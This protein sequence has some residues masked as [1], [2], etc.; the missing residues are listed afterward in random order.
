ML[1]SINIPLYFNKYMQGN[2]PDVGSRDSPCGEGNEHS[3][4]ILRTIL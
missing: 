4:V 1:V 2:V 3:S